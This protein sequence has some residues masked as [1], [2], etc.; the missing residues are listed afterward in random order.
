[1]N[2]ITIIEVP[3]YGWLPTLE[4]D[5]VEIYRG[6]FRKSVIDA[7]A[8]ADSALARVNAVKAET[9]NTIATVPECLRPVVDALLE[10]TA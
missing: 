3:G 4:Q 10:R 9:E 1:M 5:G 6:E 8:H 2:K 7:A